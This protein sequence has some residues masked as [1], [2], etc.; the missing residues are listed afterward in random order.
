[1]GTNKDQFAIL[2]DIFQTNFLYAYME[3]TLNGEKSNK[4]CLT[5]LIITQ[6]EKKTIDLFYLSYMGS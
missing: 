5:Q 2:F 4:V 1:M 3:N 6:N